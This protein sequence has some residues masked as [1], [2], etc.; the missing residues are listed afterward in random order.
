[1]DSLWDVV[2]T[3]VRVPAGAALAA[4]VFGDTSSATMLAGMLAERWRRAATREPAAGPCQH[5]LGYVFD[6]TASFG[7]D[8]WRCDVLHGP[9]SKAHS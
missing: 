5:I 9:G 3:F 1:V 6:W 8:A 4:G 7:E 2:Q